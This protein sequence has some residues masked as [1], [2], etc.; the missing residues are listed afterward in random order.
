MNLVEA[1]TGF[2]IFSLLTLAFLPAVMSL[3]KL[4]PTVNLT[5][6]NAVQSH[7]YGVNEDVQQLAIR[8]D[9]KIESWSSAIDKSSEMIV[10]EAECK[11]QP[12]NIGRFI[13]AGY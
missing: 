3:E 5:L 13:Y 10:V 11:G 1:V 4:N 12:L 2:L 9:C 7:L 8:K 6:A